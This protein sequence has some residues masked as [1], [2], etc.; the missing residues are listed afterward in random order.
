MEDFVFFTDISVYDK[1]R[2]AKGGLEWSIMEHWGRL[3]G[4]PGY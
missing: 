3:V 1:E 2:N 4:R